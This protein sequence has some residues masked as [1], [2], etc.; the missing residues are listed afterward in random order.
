MK[1][2]GKTSLSATDNKR[3]ATVHDIL[4]QRRQQQVNVANAQT[5][6]DEMK[7][8]YQDYISTMKGIRANLQ[9]ATNGLA[10]IDEKG[11][12]DKII[13]SIEAI[14]E[15]RQEQMAATS[16]YSTQMAS[17]DSKRIAYL[18]EHGSNKDKFVVEKFDEQIRQENARLRIQIDDLDHQYQDIETDLY[19]DD[20]GKHK[21][22]TDA[23]VLAAK[24]E[25]DRI[26]EEKNQ[27]ME[28]YA[29]FMQKIAVERNE[30]LHDWSN[31][32]VAVEPSQETVQKADSLETAFS[33][34][35][36]KSQSKWD[37]FKALPGISHLAVVGAAIGKKMAPKLENIKSDLLAGYAAMKESHQMRKVEKTLS[38]LDQR[39]GRTGEDSYLS[40]FKASLSPDKPVEP[41]VLDT[42]EIKV[43]E[44]VI[45][46]EPVVST[47]SEPV[48]LSPGQ[49]HENR[50]KRASNKAV[51]DSLNETGLRKIINDYYWTD[52]SQTHD[53]ATEL[54]SS[55]NA[56]T[57]LN[58]YV[59][60]IK[61]MITHWPNATYRENMISKL[62]N[63][64]M[65]TYAKKSESEKKVSAAE[66]RV[67]D[68]EEFLRSLDLPTEASPAIE[69]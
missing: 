18:R 17:F 31:E 39:Q 51:I 50:V 14:A 13:E 53:I 45:P 55:D 66:A 34:A 36:A 16:A 61:G 63:A 30:V 46:A 33:D 49:L 59:D 32:T 60:R 27:V 69:L 2:K 21:E 43:P 23:E 41:E 5:Y 6:T 1:T 68:S 8:A 26:L 20:S 64:M 57:D 9:A 4:A 22:P 24:R 11:M 56:M 58:Q 37:K 40:K 52:V 47:E 65:Q 44:T 35:A 3:Y 62:D 67:R 10:A 19:R 15:I 48:V 25:M 42:D 54:G 38:D 28:G 7:T 12:S 29:E